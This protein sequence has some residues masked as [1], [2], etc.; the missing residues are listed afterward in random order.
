MRPNLQKVVLLFQPD[1]N[2]Y[3]DWVCV[4]DVINSG[5]S[6]SN[7]GNIRRGVAFGVNE[8]NW[9]FKRLNNRKTAAILEMRLVGY[10][11]TRALSQ[12]IRKDIV[13]ILRNQTVSNF[14][15]DCIVPLVESDKEIDHR[16]GRKDS[17]KYEY[18]SDATQQSVGDFQLLS[19]SHNQFKREQCVKCKETNL[20][21]FPPNNQEFKI[22]CKDWEDNV[23][24][25]GCPLAQPELY[26]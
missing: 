1:V 11:E 2:G 13:N 19:H 3:S 25:E 24:C 9:E 8:Y 7:N 10:N 17:P 12:Y 22:G 5:L 26:R 16:W 23:G 6:W 4:D 15:P 18:I 20:R 14:A 21:Y